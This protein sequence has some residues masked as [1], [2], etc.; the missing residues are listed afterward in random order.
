MHLNLFILLLAIVSNSYYCKLQNEVI[1]LTAGEMRDFAD[2]LSGNPESLIWKSSSPEFAI[3][4]NGRVLAVQQGTT[5]I[6]AHD[7]T[8]VELLNVE[9]NVK[10]YEEQIEEDPEIEAII[11]KM[12]LE[13]KIGQMFCVGF[14]G[15]TLDPHLVEAVKQYH[16]G[17]IIY[18][19]ANVENPDT[20]GELTDQIQEL[21]I[22]HNTVPAIISTDQEGGRVARLVNKGTRFIGNMAMGGTANYTNAYLEGL[23]VGAELKH[24]GINADLAPVFDT[25]NNPENINIGVRSYSDNPIDVLKNGI[26]MYRGLKENNVMGT[27]KHFPGKGNTT[28][29]SHFDLPTITIPL[30]KLYQTELAPFIGGIYNQVDAIM[31]AHI[32]FSAIDDKKPGTLSH[33]V[34]TE[35][36]REKIG[37]TG[38]IYSDSMEMDAIDEHFGPY[39]VSACSA[40][41]AGI[42]I[43]LYTV[44]DLPRQGFEGVVE[45]LK[46]ETINESRIDDSVRRILRKKKKYGL[47]T[48]YNSSKDDISD[49][50]EENKEL[51][52]E[53]A[54]SCL[55]EV[56]GEFKGLNKQQTTL[57]ISPESPF[58]LQP[59]TSS[60]E[61]ES[62]SFGCFACDYLTSNGLSNCAFE[63]IKKDSDISE[64][65]YTKLLE[66]V[67][68][69]EQ[70]VLAFRDVKTKGYTKIA[71]L[72]NEIA[73]THK[74]FINIALQE[75]YDVLIFDEKIT[76]YICVY[77]YQR[78]SSLVLSQFLNGEITP[79]GKLP[80]HLPNI[81]NII[82]FG[83]KE[84]CSP[85]FPNSIDV[86][87]DIGTD[88]SVS[89]NL[90]LHPK[91]ETGND[92]DVTYS[93]S[94]APSQDESVNLIKT[95]CNLLTNSPA[96]VIGEYTVSTIE[97]TENIGELKPFYFYT[98]KALNNLF[99]KGINAIIDPKNQ[100]KEQKVNLKKDDQKT[101]KIVLSSPSDGLPTFFTDFEMTNQIECSLVDDVNIECSP[102]EDKME[103]GKSY[104][105]F[106]YNQCSVQHTGI[107]VSYVSST[108]LKVGVFMLA[109][110]LLF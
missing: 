80:V 57:I 58:D 78:E 110:L 1:N 39:N 49:L 105:I 27:L 97:S 107:E 79:K 18:M 44:N 52:H 106:Y 75:P 33:A 6:T 26:N 41:Y 68:K 17:N 98:K 10:K 32:I 3:V 70:I 66:E 11:A 103:L 92:K 13:Q 55:T 56:I 95:S 88:N 101:F 15:T 24:Y 46:N 82:E 31:S 36:L 72:V 20:L 61:L 109:I 42:D 7:F 37:Y 12:T 81:T 9:I 5:T 104:Q 67:S 43:L 99:Q 64:E 63:T 28:L 45:C 14:S 47:L 90:I 51:N 19:G 59:G 54:K 21:M 77:G 16:F 87:A 84:Q 48:N 108:F 62:N 22:K 94:F 65:E 25:N 53:F 8:G 89:A 83:F 50:L 93:C 34:L 38:I 60:F 35:L 102:T 73:K 100:L 74:N 2:R 86:I 96:S 4:H 29:D 71:E 30:D 76:N 23:A 85:T 91:G 40:V 69:Y